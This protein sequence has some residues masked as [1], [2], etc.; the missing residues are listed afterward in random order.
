MIVTDCVCFS[1][2]KESVLSVIERDQEVSSVPVFD[3]LSLLLPSDTVPRNSI[4]AH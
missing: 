4:Y 1:P 2:R 3:H